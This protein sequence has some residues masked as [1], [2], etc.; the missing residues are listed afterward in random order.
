VDV[1]NT[2]VTAET[3]SH[4][5][6]V[7][8]AAVES[9]AS[10]CNLALTVGPSVD[11][12]GDPQAEALR[13]FIALTGDIDWSLGLLLP[14]DTAVAVVGRFAGFEIAFDSPDMGDAVG[15]LANLVGGAAKAKLDQLGVKAELSL[16]TVIRGSHMEV[17]NASRAMAVRHSFASPVGGMEVHVLAG[18][19]GVS[20][21]K[22]GA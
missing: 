18:N 22:S 14:R 11:P 4:A 17:A 6:C 15:E 7:V 10:T 12:S 20:L 3:F 9:F 8:E 19:G 16:P 5:S 13:A 1:S 21:R 2:A